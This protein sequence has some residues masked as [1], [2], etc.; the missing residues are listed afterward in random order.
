MKKVSDALKEV[1]EISQL[2][3]QEIWVAGTTHLTDND[4]I[5]NMSQVKPGLISHLDDA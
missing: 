2:K 4:K 3:K 5:T 1:V